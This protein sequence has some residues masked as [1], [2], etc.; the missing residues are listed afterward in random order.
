MLADRR[1]AAVAQDDAAIAGGVRCLEGENGHG[2]A[3]GEGRPQAGKGLGRHERRVGESDDDIVNRER[4]GR[5][6]AQDRMPS[7]ETLALLE[8]LDPGNRGAG[9]FRDIGAIGPDHHRDA[10]CAGASH[11]FQDMTDHG[12]SGDLV[13]HLRP[14]GFHPVPFAGG[15]DDGKAGAGGNICGHL[16]IPEQDAAGRWRE[17]LAHSRGKPQCA[18]AAKIAALTCD[19]RL[20]RRAKSR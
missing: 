10:A 18:F 3:P 14:R 15:E 12:Q 7:A 8:G 20:L 5:A 9:Y 19:R 6:G 16:A 4:Q 2:G 13:Q 11:R 17:E 1:R